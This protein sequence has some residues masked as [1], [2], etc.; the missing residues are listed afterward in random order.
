[1]AGEAFFVWRLVMPSADSRLSFCYTVHMYKLL[2]IYPFSDEY[3]RLVEGFAAYDGTLGDPPGAPHR[4]ID[5]V[6]ERNGDYLPFD[7]FAMHDGRAYRGMSQSWGSFVVI[8]HEIPRDQVRFD[9]VYA[10]LDELDE[11]IPVLDDKR[12]HQSIGARKEVRVGSWIGKT[13]TSGTTNDIVQLHVELHR[14]DL[15]TGAWEKLD[16]YGLYER[17]SSGR[18]LQ[19]SASLRGLDHA[20]TSDEPPLAIV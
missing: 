2:H 4:G 3:V 10:H 9:T 14:K 6:L 1:V 11:R 19:P 15:Q 5:Y 18:Y 8:Q 12:E 20:W 7:I 17:F 16:P 13:G